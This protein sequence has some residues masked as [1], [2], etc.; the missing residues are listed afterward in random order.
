MDEAEA[1]WEPL[2]TFKQSYSEFQLDEELFVEA[3][4][5]VMTGL[6]FSRRNK[7]QRG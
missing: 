5:V 2:E 7:R 1:T 3:G 4:R 6:K